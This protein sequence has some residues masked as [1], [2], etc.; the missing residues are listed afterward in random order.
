VCTV[1]FLATLAHTQQ[2]DVAV[3]GGTTV[4]FKNEVSSQA[5][6]PP[7]I[8]GGTYPSVS[9]GVLLRKRYGLNVETSW[10]D[11]K[12]TYNGYE[13]YRPI[14]TDVNA[15]FQPM[16]RKKIGLDLMAGVG[17]DRNEFYLPGITCGSAEGTC[18]VSSNHFM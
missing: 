15:L 3:G 16:L 9:A 10:R 11:K 2:I 5:L 18:Y 7:Q 1:L 6:L 12:T 13:S 4:A 17:I 14:F 8:K